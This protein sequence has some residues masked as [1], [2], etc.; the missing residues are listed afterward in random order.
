M[1]SMQKAI[2]EGT[3]TAFVL[4]MNSVYAFPDPFSPLFLVSFVV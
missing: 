3:P 2:T 4:R 1:D